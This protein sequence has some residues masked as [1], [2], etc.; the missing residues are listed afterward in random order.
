L[1]L[2]FTR[3]FGG[4]KKREELKQLGRGKR[5]RKNINYR[6]TVGKKKADSSSDSDDAE[7]FHPDDEESSSEDENENNS[8]Q[9]INDDL[10]T[11]GKG[12][13]QKQ[14]PKAHKHVKEESNHKDGSRTDISAIHVTNIQKH[15]Q[16]PEISTTNN[17]LSCWYQQTCIYE[18]LSTAYSNP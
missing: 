5:K 16:Q 7:G 2:Y 15:V 12:S 1:G 8:V 17:T 18:F 3:A 14:K 9:M 13:K 6:E 11:D 4:K 10:R